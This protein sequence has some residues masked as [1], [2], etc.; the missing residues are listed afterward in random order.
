MKKFTN[1][2]IPVKIE[3]KTFYNYSNL[4]SQERKMFDNIECHVTILSGC[5]STFACEF[6]ATRNEG[7]SMSIGEKINLIRGSDTP[8]ARLLSEL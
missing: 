6:A 5:T 2:E 7:T 3:D 4:P 1:D 8:R